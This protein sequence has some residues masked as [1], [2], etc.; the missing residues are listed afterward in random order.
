M[1]HVETPERG[2]RRMNDAYALYRA[3]AKTLGFMP[4]GGFEARAERGT[5]LVTVE[6]GQTIGFALHDLPGRRVACDNFASVIRLRGGV[7]P[8]VV[9]RR[10]TLPVGRSIHRSRLSR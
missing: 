6:G 5:L 1:M 7:S 9:I 8:G 2:S 4:I 10:M 3:H